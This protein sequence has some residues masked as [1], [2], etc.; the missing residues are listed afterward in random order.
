MPTVLDLLEYIADRRNSF[1]GPIF[2]SLSGYCCC[3]PYSEAI[4]HSL[5]LVDV[6]LRGGLSPPLGL[7]VL[8]MS[9]RSANRRPK[10]AQRA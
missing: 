6:L 3:S 2:A 9:P 1:S 7:F 4:L 5:F 10:H 8:A